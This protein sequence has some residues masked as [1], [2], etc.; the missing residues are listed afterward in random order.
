MTSPHR[1]PVRQ[2]GGPAVSVAQELSRR[3]L[4][5]HPERMQHSSAV[6]ARAASL[7]GAVDDTDVNL[8][9]AAAWVHDIG[10][11]SA[12][13]DTGFHPLDGARFLASLHWDP[14]LCAL[15]AHHSGSRFVAEVTGLDS[16]LGEF[17]HVQ[18]AVSDALTIAD[19]TVGPHGRRLTLDER[20]RDTLGR[21]GPESPQAR[22]HAQR[23]E[24]FRAA[25]R[26]VDARLATR[27]VGEDREPS[28]RPHSGSTPSLTARLLLPRSRQ[29]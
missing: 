10:Y 3:M 20:M 19:Q 23:E 7:A 28:G 8:L 18:D 9:V 15:V 22:A 14:R 29:P 16:A 25:L 11:A 26:R 13:R 24:Y 1:M 12:L 5:A 4:A 2:L 17:L 6:A 21:H 27:G